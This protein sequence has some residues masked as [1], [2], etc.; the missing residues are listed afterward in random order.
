MMNVIITDH[1]WLKTAM[2]IPK[3]LNSPDTG[4]DGFISTRLKIH[5]GS[6]SNSIC[7]NPAPQYTSWADLPVKGIN[8]FIEGQGR[9]YSEQEDFE[10]MV[11]FRMGVPAFTPMTYFFG[12]RGFY[13]TKAGIVARTGRAPKVSFTI[14]QAVGKVV[15]FLIPG[16][17]L[18][19]AIAWTLLPLMG[20]MWGFITNRPRHR[21]YYSK[22]AMVNYWSMVDNIFNGIMVKEGIIDAFAPK[23]KEG[24]RYDDESATQAY[25]RL[26]SG[27][28]Q[29][30]AELMPGI[31]RE[32]GGVDVYAYATR[33]TRNQI[34]A[35]EVINNSNSWTDAV[36]EAK[37]SGQSFRSAAIM[38]T[39]YNLID[40]FSVSEG[41]K[42]RDEDDEEKPEMDEDV[43]VSGK[44]SFVKE[45]FRDG[46]DWITLR[47]N[48]T[49]T[50]SDSFNNSTGESEL[51]P[52]INGATAAIRSKTFALAGGNIAAPVNEMLDALKQ[53]AQ[54]IAS[55]MG[56][57]AL[58]GVLSG[59]GYADLPH[60]WKDAT[61][62]LH[63]LSY[64]IQLRADAADPIS[65]AFQLW[66]PFSCILAMT[67]SQAVGK[68]AYTSPFLIEVYDRGRG[69]STLCMVE[70]CSF[71]R[72]VGNVGWTEDGSPLGIDITL[73]LVRL[74]K[75]LYVPINNN[76]SLF[77]A[78]SKFEEY[79]N[80][81]AGQ[82][83]MDQYYFTRRAKFRWSRKMTSF[84]RYTSPAYWSMKAASTPTGKL[85]RG[86]MRLSGSDNN[87]T[88]T[89]SNRGIMSGTGNINPIEF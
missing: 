56:L 66:L 33:A 80:V 1:E 75:I 47:V 41:G 16:I 18:K 5:D 35:T 26:D 2:I 3:N 11:H 84:R 6:H 29:A 88:T 42:P 74:D 68:A 46:G 17:N 87:T 7:L 89:I 25:D 52:L 69:Q 37:N 49:G 70:S 21:Y 31:W 8:P 32:S 59:I 51:Q 4:S 54:G 62:D 14:G 13:D 77:S 27:M 82:S 57:D 73:N 72:G 24:Q 36:K 81:L 45:A 10:Q 60:E 71:E 86:A 19:F 78:D 65:R 39:L 12:P 63:S 83:L 50:A 64:K 85:I 55:G 48:H 40:K 20:E 9:F 28:N 15:P 61:T 53:G 34:R 76:P 23:M 22:P 30:M 79:L 67:A 44:S 43:E 58:N 38:G